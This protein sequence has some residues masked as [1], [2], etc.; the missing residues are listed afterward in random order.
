MTATVGAEPVAPSGRSHVGRGGAG[1][2]VSA[3]SR[4]RQSLHPLAWW[5]WAL[6]LTVLASATTNPLLLLV[7]CAVA[8]VVVTERRSRAPWAAAYGVFLKIALFTLVLRLVLQVLVGVEVG[9]TVLVRLPEV[10][11][12]DWAA[13]VRLGGP[14]TAES[15]L[16]ALG[17]G[18]R[19]ATVLILLGAANALAAP[20]RL[21]R[22]LPAALYELGVATTVAM[23]FAP[24]AVVSLS[25]VRAARRLRHRPVN[26]PRALRGT[27]LPVLEGA[28]DRAVALAAAMD[29]RGYGRQAEQSTRQRRL[30]AALTLTGLLATCAGTYGLLGAGAPGALGLP[31]VLVGAALAAAGLALGGRRAVRTRYRPDRFGLAEWLVVGSAALAAAV[32]LSLGR[33]AELLPAVEPLGFP[34]LP[35][36]PVLAALVALLPALVAPRPSRVAR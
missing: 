27:A 33:R 5:G 1:R 21:L 24:Q 18:L 2:F 13:G 31:T 30:T 11:L 14:V 16:A 20:S 12:P 10:P 29:S 23:S 32:T 7:V 26:G 19:L 22:T 3:T 17:A 35:V 36:L 25:R 15:L 6:A 28:L 4:R 34:P 8:A 9:S